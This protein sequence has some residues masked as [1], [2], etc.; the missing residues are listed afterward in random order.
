MK[1]LESRGNNN[2]LAAQPPTVLS[3][4]ATVYE[5]T[6]YMQ[7]LRVCYIEFLATGWSVSRADLCSKLGWFP[8]IAA[9]HPYMPTGIWPSAVVAV[10]A[11]M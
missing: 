3:N 8:A 1:S 10:Q 5:S 9:Q 2:S 4:N 11:D 7:L 6:A